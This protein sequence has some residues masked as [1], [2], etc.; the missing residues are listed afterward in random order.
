M[1][2]KKVEID[3]NTHTTYPFNLPLFQ[4]KVVI[5]LNN[6][7]TIF[8]GDNGTGKSSIL[9]LIQSKLNLP[10][11]QIPQD[12]DNFEINSNEVKLDFELLKPKGFYF[13]SIKFINYVEYIQKELEYSSK[14][15]Q[16][17]EVEYKHKS[18]YAKLM[19]ETPFKRTIYELQNMYSKDF[20]K[21]SHGEAYLAFFSSRIK[22]NQLYLLDEPETPL[23][24]QNQ[25]T[26]MAMILEA[27]KRGCQFVIATHSPILV[28]IPKALIYEIDQSE[29][30]KTS[31]EEIKSIQLLKQFLNQPDQFQKHFKD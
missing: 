30:L 20:T 22:D 31:F 19:V 12:K 1:L 7:V 15:L 16:R 18:A 9:K 14:E 2:L 3:N 25:L 8:V 23:S 28:A 26:L 17:I 5:D 4:K 13:E 6:S 21:S 11:I 29:L 27:T 10:K 24:V